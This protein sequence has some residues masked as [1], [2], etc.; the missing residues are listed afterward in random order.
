MICDHVLYVPE[1]YDRH[2]EYTFPGWESPEVFGREAPIEV[3]YCTGNGAWIA[4][5]ALAHPDRNWVAVEIQFDRVRKIWS[6]IH[7]LN[8]KNLF[9]VCGDGL[10]FTKYYAPSESFSSLYVNFPDPWPKEKHAKNRLLREPFL[11]EMA[12]ASKLG[13]IAT[14]VTDHADYMTQVVSGM[15]ASPAWQPCFPEPHYVTEFEG[16]GTSYFD[17][18]WREQGIKIHYMQFKNG[19]MQ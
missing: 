4:E 6:K 13:A 8:L 15:Q 10:A 16:Y 11:T 19:K 3:E 14:I 1:Y 18:L 9:I 17:A 5:R 7:N 12:R 2:Q